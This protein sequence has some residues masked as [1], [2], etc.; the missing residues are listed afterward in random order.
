MAEGEG[1]NIDV[2]QKA[3]VY[4]DDGRVLALR[5]TETAPSRPLYWDLPGGL[6]EVGEDL[7]DAIEREVYEESGVSVDRPRILDAVGRT[8]DDGLYLVTIGYRARATTTEVTLSFE[9]DDWQWVT[10][11]E[12][13][14]LKV[15]PRNTQFVTAFIHQEGR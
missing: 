2:A 7:A 6:V 12:F 3:V 9:H 1:K 8:L 11:A 5:R 14:D 13:L 4:R 15:S 10:P